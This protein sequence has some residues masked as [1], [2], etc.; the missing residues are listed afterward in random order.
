MQRIQMQSTP[1]SQPLALTLRAG[2]QAGVLECDALRV[3]LD[4]KMHIPSLQLDIFS[5]VKDIRARMDNFDRATIE[6]IC[7][8]IDFVRT[9]LVF[10][11]Y[12]SKAADVEPIV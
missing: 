10:G 1:R 4:K 5:I 7:Q 2:R 8:S 9:A 3:D 11:R 6:N 12:F